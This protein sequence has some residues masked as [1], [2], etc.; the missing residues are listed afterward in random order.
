MHIVYIRSTQTHGDFLRFVPTCMIAVDRC[1]PR[2]TQRGDDGTITPFLRRRYVLCCIVH[3]EPVTLTHPA[4]RANS[5]PTSVNDV[6]QE[7]REHS[8]PNA[9]SY[10]Q[11]RKSKGRRAARAYALQVLRGYGKEHRYRTDQ[12]LTA[13]FNQGDP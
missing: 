8:K 12:S 6:V 9:F 2:P 10:V 13:F 7:R 11:I 1:R 3:R 5:D 4:E